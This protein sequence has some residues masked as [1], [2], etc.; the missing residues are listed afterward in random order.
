MQEVV[1]LYTKSRADMPEPLQASPTL[2]SRM[3]KPD[4]AQLSR[5]IGA[6]AKPG[7]VCP[8]TQPL[9]D[10]VKSSIILT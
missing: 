6:A 1:E 2:T 9:L 7:M 10:F 5:S 3:E 4:K 8:V